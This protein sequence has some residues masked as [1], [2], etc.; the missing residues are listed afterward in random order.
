MGMASV[1]V[2]VIDRLRVTCDEDGVVTVVRT[3]EP[4]K[5]KLLILDGAHVRFG[6]QSVRLKRQRYGWRKLWR[7]TGE[8]EVICMS[9]ELGLNC[10]FEIKPGEAYDF[11]CRSILPIRHVAPA[12]VL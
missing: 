6:P 3:A 8:I 4:H 7:P 11:T 1:P 10:D 2:P 12:G 5:A 9:N